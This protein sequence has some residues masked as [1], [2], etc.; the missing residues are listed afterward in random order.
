MRFSEEDVGG[1]DKHGDDGKSIH[2]QTV[3]KTQGLENILDISGRTPDA[4]GEAVS[5]EG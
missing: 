3:A 4:S 2:N 5:L 1:R